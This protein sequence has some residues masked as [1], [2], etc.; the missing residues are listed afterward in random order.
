MDFSPLTKS[1]SNPSSGDD[2][3]GAAM[4]SNIL[5]SSLLFWSLVVALISS[6]LGGVS[7]AFAHGTFFSQSSSQT[8]GLE[9][10]NQNSYVAILSP[11]YLLIVYMLEIPQSWSLPTKLIPHHTLQFIPSSHRLT[12]IHLLG[13]ILC[14]TVKTRCSS[15]YLLCFR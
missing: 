15:F 9:A 7:K 4:I 10:F 11:R 14:F 6:C 12:L 13:P 2:D 1:R 3:M 5:R 8:H